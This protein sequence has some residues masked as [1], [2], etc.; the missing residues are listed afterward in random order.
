MP[1]VESGEIQFSRKH[2]LLLEQFEMYPTGTHDDLPDALEM[3][4]SIAKTSGKKLRNKPA[5]M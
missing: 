2:A 1:A 4:V 3:A 5:W